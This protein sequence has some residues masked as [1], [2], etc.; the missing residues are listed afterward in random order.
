MLDVKHWIQ[1]ANKGRR[2]AYSTFVNTVF[3]TILM[4]TSLMV[5]STIKVCYSSSS[6]TAKIRL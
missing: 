2:S 6:E 3:I 1:H 5:T 4:V